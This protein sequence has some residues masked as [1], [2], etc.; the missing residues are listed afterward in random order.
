[1]IASPLGDLVKSLFATLAIF[2]RV[3]NFLS[4]VLFRLLIAASNRRGVSV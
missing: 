2:Q 1:M 3:K 4:T